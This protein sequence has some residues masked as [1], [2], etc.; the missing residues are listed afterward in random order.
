MQKMIE[1]MLITKAKIENVNQEVD[2]SPECTFL[3][4]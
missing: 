2:N 4:K 3:T 1:K